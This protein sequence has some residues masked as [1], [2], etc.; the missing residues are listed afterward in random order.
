MCRGQPGFNL[1]GFSISNWA[2]SCG[3]NDPHLHNRPPSDTFSAMV[4]GFELRFVTLGSRHIS[5]VVLIGG[6]EDNLP[7]K[8]NDA[9]G[10]CDISTNNCMVLNNL[11]VDRML[12]L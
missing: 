11:V 5:S 8:K 10:V 6:C 9:G 4:T 3:P 2:S 1:T 12:E 7:L